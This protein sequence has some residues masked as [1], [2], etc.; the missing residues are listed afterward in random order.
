M[1]KSGKMN[2]SSDLRMDERVSDFTGKISMFVKNMY[3]LWFI[4]VDSSIIAK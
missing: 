3:I 1:V 2:V 4:E